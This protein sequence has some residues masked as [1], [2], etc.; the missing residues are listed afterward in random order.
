MNSLLNIWVRLSR[1]F[2]DLDP[3]L[4]AAFWTGLSY[5]TSG[6]LSVVNGE[7]TLDQFKH[8]MAVSGLGHLIAFFIYMAAHSGSKMKLQ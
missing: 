8:S 5:L 2:D 3:K 1:K 7:M 6:L 4:K